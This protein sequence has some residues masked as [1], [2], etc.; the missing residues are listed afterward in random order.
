MDSFAN[1]AYHASMAEH[2]PCVQARSIHRRICLLVEYAP[3]AGTPD[4]CETMAEIRAQ[5]ARICLLAGDKAGAAAAMQASDRWMD[6]AGQRRWTGTPMCGDDVSE[7]FRDECGRL[8][9]IIERIAG[10]STTT[11]KYI[12]TAPGLTKDQRRQLTEIYDLASGGVHRNRDDVTVVFDT[13]AAADYLR[14]VESAT[15]S[16]P[17]WRTRAQ[18]D[19]LKPT[20]SAFQ[21]TLKMRSCRAKVQTATLATTGW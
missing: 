15:R 18:T 12:L 1:H 21:D 10:S 19:P 14:G 20:P 8:R 3:P 16:K 17:D 9:R 11:K 2:A 5:E 6:A 13:E 4:R 7:A